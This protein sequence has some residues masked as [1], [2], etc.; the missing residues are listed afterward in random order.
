MIF[1]LDC[2]KLYFLILN[3]NSSNYLLLQY[4][5]QNEAMLGMT[6]NDVKSVKMIGR[7]EMNMDSNMK[8]FFNEINVDNLRF[9]SLAKPYFNDAQDFVQKL[10]FTIGRFLNSIIRRVFSLPFVAQ[11]RFLNGKSSNGKP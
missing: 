11:L 7:R 10:I 2:I 4:L 1:I 3:W 5:K 8:D 9:G 6:G